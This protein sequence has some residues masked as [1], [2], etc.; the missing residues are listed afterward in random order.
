M[1]HK[2]SLWRQEFPL[3]Y[4]YISS[5]RAASPLSV[6]T[7]SSASAPART[8]KRTKCI[9]AG[10]R[11]SNRLDL[12]ST[13]KAT[14]TTTTASRLTPPSRR[15]TDVAA[16]AHIVVAGGVIVLQTHLK[17]YPNHNQSASISLLFH[18]SVPPS[19]SPL[20]LALC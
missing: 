2:T 4:R 8:L 15:H 5:S 20:K 3:R 9:V 18:S 19:Q 12:V 7:S 11:N 10:K 17:L 1:V 14:V 13:A 16:V 6:A